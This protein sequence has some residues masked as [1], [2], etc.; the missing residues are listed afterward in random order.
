MSVCSFDSASAKEAASLYNKLRDTGKM[1]N[2]ND[3][4]VAGISLAND[5]V[6]FTRDQKFGAIN[7]AKI[8]II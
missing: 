6:L 8:K 3:L 1:I 7:N 2:E 5:E 4:L